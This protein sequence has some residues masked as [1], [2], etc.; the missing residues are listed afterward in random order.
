MNRSMFVLVLAFILAFSSMACSLT[1]NL[2]VDDVT[3]GPTQ[4]EEI[5]I[6]APAGAEDP[7]LVVG[8]GAGKLKINPG[9]EAYLVSGTATYNVSDFKP[10]VIT[11]GDTVQLET[12]SL[13]LE[14]FPNFSNKMVNEWDLE[15]GDMPLALEINAGAYEGRLDLG[16]LSLLSLEVSDGAAN[17]ELDFS[18]PNKVEM[19]KLRY[20]TGAS[21]VKLTG[22][23]NANFTSMAFKSGAGDYTLDFSGDLQH[24]AEVKIE[25]GISNVTIIVPE[26]VSARLMF[27]GGMTSTSLE[28]GWKKDGGEYTHAGS[29]PTI[30]I[31]VTMGAGNLNLKSAQS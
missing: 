7:K 31:R 15:L 24:D 27:D 6:N 20:S 22:L 5:K 8:F 17:V 12:G 21:N 23:A 14:G 1:I 28:G 18:E 26:G 16:G 3:T 2:P 10:R 30:I 29:G 25:S 13:N 19:E 9:E 4:E 11:S